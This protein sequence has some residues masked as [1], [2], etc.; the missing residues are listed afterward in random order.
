[1]SGP[2]SG[3]SMSGIFGVPQNYYTLIGGGVGLPDDDP[4]EIRA[5]WLVPGTGIVDAISF[6][7][8]QWDAI[9][10]L[11]YAN[12]LNM[13]YLSGIGSV[14]SAKLDDILASV[15]HTYVTP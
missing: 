10:Q 5:H 14:A 9:S 1:M 2:V 15:R 12:Y 6:T 3:L 7:G 13:G 11:A 4:V 8:F